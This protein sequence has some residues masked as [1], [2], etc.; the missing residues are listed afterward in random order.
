MK[1]KI[2]NWQSCG[3]MQS[4][5]VLLLDDR[6]KPLGHFADEALQATLD[7]DFFR[8]LCVNWVS[9]IQQS[10]L[11]KP[12]RNLWNSN[13]QEYLKNWKKT[14]KEAIQQVTQACALIKQRLQKKQLLK[15]RN[16]ASKL[17][18][19]ESILNGKEK[20]CIQSYYEV[21]NE[22]LQDLL[23]LLFEIG[24]NEIIVDLANIHYPKDSVT[25]RGKHIK[26]SSL[27]SIDQTKLIQ[28]ID[29]LPVKR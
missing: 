6:L 2:K 26:L 1:G 24:E 29:T 18:S 8:L 14:E 25:F 15:K 27:A 7:Y 9:S 4:S 12:L 13:L 21:A 22:R 23:L 3:N 28:Q 5:Y 20:V 11:L 16:I 17:I 10:P 19:V